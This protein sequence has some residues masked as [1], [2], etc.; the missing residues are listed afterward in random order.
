LERISVN[1]VQSSESGSGGIP[2][3]NPDIIQEFKVQ[4]GIYDAAYGSYAGANVS[5]I[6]KTDSN[7][8]HGS[9]FELLRDDV[10]NANGS[11]LSRPAPLES[12][13]EPVRI[14]P[15]GAIKRDRLFFFGSYQGIRA[16]NLLAGRITH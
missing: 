16:M 8:F 14:C 10:L 5:V 2:I 13:A 1:D 6:T 3:P 11:F 7:S 9:I 15:L 12:H 4:T